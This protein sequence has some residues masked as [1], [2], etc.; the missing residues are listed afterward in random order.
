MI[1]IQVS[2]NL[3]ILDALHAEYCNIS[4]LFRPIIIYFD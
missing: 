4:I 1:H 3:L 2:D